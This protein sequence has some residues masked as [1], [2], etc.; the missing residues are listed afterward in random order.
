MEWEVDPINTLGLPEYLVEA[1]K[2]L[3]QTPI[4]DAEQ[5]GENIPLY[6]MIFWPNEAILNQAIGQAM[7]LHPNYAESVHTEE[8][9]H[10]FLE[11]ISEIIWEKTSEDLTEESIQTIEK[12]VEIAFITQEIT[13]VIKLEQHYTSLKPLGQL[14]WER[15]SHQLK[16]MVE[17]KALLYIT[18]NPTLLKSLKNPN[19]RRE[20]PDWIRGLIITRALQGNNGSRETLNPAS[21]IKP[22]AQAFREAAIWVLNTHLS[23]GN[24]PQYIE[25]TIKTFEDLKIRRK[26]V[27]LNLKTIPANEIIPE[28]PISPPLSRT[29]GSYQWL[30][31]WGFLPNTDIEVRELAETWSKSSKGSDNIKSQYRFRI[32]QRVITFLIRQQILQKYDARATLRENWM[33]KTGIKEPIMEYLKTR[34]PKE[35]RLLFSIIF[36]ESVWKQF[37]PVSKA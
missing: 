4:K 26:K 36:T 32:L 29:G 6:K 1:C 35:N 17:D 31:C 9:K 30:L 34:V 20:I 15:S 18:E 14:F 28:T 10:E 2:A 27:N 22:D 8:I 3:A 11:E 7:D 19:A 13:K 24:Q 37:T 16:E 25:D 5:K 23:I 12:E 33:A 21:R